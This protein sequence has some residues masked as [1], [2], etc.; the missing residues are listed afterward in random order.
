MRSRVDGQPARED[1]RLERTRGRL[2]R[3]ALEELVA[4]GWGGFTVE[5]VA[6]RAGAGKASVYR[7]YGDR[8]ALVL[9]AFAHLVVQ[10][11]R[12]SDRP[13]PVRAIL[14]HL[15]EGWSGPLLPA[16][17]DAAQRDPD[18]ATAL[19]A[20]SAERLGGLAR[21]VAV[22][23]EERGDGRDPRAVAE[24]LAGALLYRRLVSPGRLTA[25]DV[26]TVTAA[27]MG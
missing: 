12:G 5:G 25:G 10:P 15:V 14:E 22:E 4:A 16:L 21:A 19:R 23:L 18:M 9:D 3:A 11:G 26:D 13:V 7:L 8:H 24:A 17:V 1:P 2:R 6:R 27:V 20:S